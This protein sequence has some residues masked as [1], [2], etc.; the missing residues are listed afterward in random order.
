MRI[1]VSWSG[2]TSR[3]VAEALRD[4]L[5]DVLQDVQPWMSASDIDAGVR[6][7]SEI[8]K[9][10][11]GS[12]FGVICLTPDNTDA[13]WILFESG[14]LSKKFDNSRVIPYLFRL[15]QSDIQ[16][17]L[18]QFQNVIADKEG[19]RRL[20]NS[21]FI[22]S[23]NTPVSVDRLDRA[24]EQWWPSLEARL[25]GIPAT[26]KKKETKRSD[27]DLLDEIL[28]TVRGLQRSVPSLEREAERERMSNRYL[29]SVRPSGS[30]LSEKATMA[31]RYIVDEE[32]G[33]VLTEN[34]YREYQSNRAI[35]AARAAAARRAK[36]EREADESS[37]SSD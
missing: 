31:K 24:F 14:A 21:I 35:V 27:N 12:D 20:V 36:A 22:A 9:Y 32:P 25:D 3:L 17:P 5:P 10:L 6:W 37:D 26:K 19:T 23:D 8:G 15:S 28:G 7:A 18:A 4:W 33:R 16:G 13:P 11:E 29:R 1:F 30:S 2:T 34:E